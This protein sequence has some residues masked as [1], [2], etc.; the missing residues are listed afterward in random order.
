M[1]FI[2]GC[3]DASED[4]IRDVFD[5]YIGNVEGHNGTAVLE[6]IDEKYIEQMDYLM[7]AARTANHDQVFKMSASERVWIAAIRN[8]LTREEVSK[9]DGRALLQLS[10][11]KGWNLDK[12]GKRIDRSLGLITFRKPRAFAPMVANGTET[13]FSY[14]FVQ[15]DHKWK[16]DPGCADKYA[17]KLI[18]ELARLTGMREDTWI[19]AFEKAATGKT[20]T[21]AIWDPPK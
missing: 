2:P 8:R 11:D 16:I 13:T 17:D 9:L 20:L 21:D 19:K 15:V 18:E 1:L 5:S 10:V 3:D 12:A 6:L 14:E 4:E 7:N